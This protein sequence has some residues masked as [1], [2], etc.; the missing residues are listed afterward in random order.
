MT[1]V[2][3]ARSTLGRLVLAELRLYAVIVP[4]LLRRKDVPSGGQAWPY[5]ALVTPVLWLWVFGSAT[6]VVV[7]HLILPWETVRLV[8][9]VI[10][11]W[12]LVWMVG[13]LAAYRVRPHVLLPDQLR[14]RNGV[15]HDIAVPTRDILSAVAREVELPSAMRSLHVAEDGEARHVSVGV[16]GRTNVVLT[17]R[18][19]TPLQTASGTVAASTLGL[20]VDEPRAF[21]AEVRRVASVADGSSGTPTSTPPR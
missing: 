18:P 1:D 17:L 11:I 4:W 12:G 20:W 2:A 16:S 3:G 6:E 21:V 15:Q 10:G 9:D 5:A 8:A 19:G 7:L 13:L 14:V